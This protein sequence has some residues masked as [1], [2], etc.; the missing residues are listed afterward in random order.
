MVV[1]INR[2]NTIAGTSKSTFELAV[3]VYLKVCYNNKLLVFVRSELRTKSPVVTCQ[4]QEV[5]IYL[6]TARLNINVY[7]VV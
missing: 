5:W 7:T 2:T 3:K 4:P 6:S 1:V